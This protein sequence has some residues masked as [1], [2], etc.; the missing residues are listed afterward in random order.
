M[1]DVASALDAGPL[2]VAVSVTPFA[3]RRATTVPSDEHTTV[4]VIDDPDDPDGVNEQPVAEPSFEKSPAAIP[5]TN[6][7]N[8]SV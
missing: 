3:A 5:L 6:S 2:F 4:T 1:T 7:P 8:T